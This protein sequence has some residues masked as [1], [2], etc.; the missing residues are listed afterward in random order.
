MGAAIDPRL[1]RRARAVRVLL[2]T[3]AC[4]GVVAALLVL[5]QAVL[6]ARV[7]ARGFEGAS[8]A[9]VAR[10][11]ELL[12]RRGGGAGGARLGLRD[13]RPPRRAADAVGPA[14]RPRR[15]PP[16]RPTSRPRPHD[17]GR[18]R[19]PGRVGRGRAR[20]HV[21]ALPAAARPRA[22]RPCRRARDRRVDRPDFRRRDAADAA[23]RAAVHVARRTLHRAPLA[24]PAPG[25]DGALRALPRRRPRA[26][27][28]ARVQPERV[29]GGADRDG[30]RRVPAHDDGDAA[31]GVPLR[32]DPRAGSDA[33]DR[34]RRRHRRRAARRRRASGSRRR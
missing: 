3:D 10:P 2:V 33:R 31:G 32:R 34:A 23:A 16:A 5:A 30:Q 24:G 29:P 20:D 21:H 25:A 11:L 14:R 22:R 19:N 1:M 15:Q 18:G 9:E 7:A 4:L 12:V 26:A 17:L 6:L 27:D 28:A 8:L 13:G